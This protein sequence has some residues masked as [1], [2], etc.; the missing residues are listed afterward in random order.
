MC[1]RFTL[2]TSKIS[3]KA[4]GVTR[5]RYMPPARFNIAPTTGIAVIR[6]EEDGDRELVEMRWGL[7]PIWAK[8]ESK[9]PL[10]INARAETVATKPA[11]R[12]AFK[13]RRCIV[14]ATGYY[15]W[16][17]LPDGTKQ[18]FYF[19]GKDRIPLAFAAIWEGET[20]ATI[21]T[22]P[23]QE[24]AQVHDR[25]PVILDRSQF[26]RWMAPSPLS[27]EES[28]LFMRPLPEGS[29]NVHPVDRRVGSVRFDEP[30]LIEPVLG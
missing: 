8:P 5:T 12:S 18:P 24:A 30:S 3:L 4:F 11:F 27:A 14:P 15:E 23:N 10:M 16:K 26:D 1:G 6:Q 20:A 17:K 22:E 2:D 25:M 29:L 7:V 28:R 9:L 13:T 19:T 21:T